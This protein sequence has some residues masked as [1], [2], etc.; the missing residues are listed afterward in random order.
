MHAKKIKDIRDIQERLSSEYE[1]LIK[2]INRSRIAAFGRLRFFQEAMKAM[3]RG[4]Y[5][6]WVRRRKPG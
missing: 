1:S 2:S 5:G 3:D 4:Q 6:E